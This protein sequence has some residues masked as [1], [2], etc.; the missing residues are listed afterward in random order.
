M[1]PAIYLSML[2]LLLLYILS[3]WFLFGGDYYND[4]I[5]TIVTGLFVVASAIPALLWLTWRRN[6]SDDAM[7]DRTF[8]D[9]AAGEFETWTGKSNGI[10]SAVEALLPIAAVA[11]GL[12]VLG[13]IFDVVVHHAA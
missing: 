3:V 11:V 12:T 6:S 5:F 4:L 7:D 1:H 9:W 10:N 13:V 2:A 8:R